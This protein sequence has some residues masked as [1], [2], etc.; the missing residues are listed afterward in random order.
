MLTAPTRGV[1]ANRTL[2]LRSVRAVGFDM[3]YTL[4]HYRVEKWEQ[5]AYEHARSRLLDRSWP[6]AACS[7]QPEL[8]TLGLIVDLQLGNLVKATRFGYVTQAYHGERAVG[9]DELRRSYN[10][11]LVDL[12]DERWVFLN[13][14]FSISEATLFSQCVDLHDQ[15]KL[16]VQLSYAELYD[17]VRRAID[18]VHVE[19]NLKKQI[20]QN[21]APFVEVDSQVVETLV[22]L[23]RA[24]K[25]LLLITN[26][27][28]SY[29]EALM[30]F[31]FDAELPAATTWR[32]L[33]ELVVVS[34]RKPLFFTDKNP[35]FEVL[36]NQGTLRP[37]NGK[38][39]TGGVYFGGHAGLI[40]EHLGL[41]ADDILYIGDHLYSDVHVSKDLLRWR[42]G[43]V[44]RELEK[45]LLALDTFR[46]QQAQLS[47]L[48]TQKKRLEHEYATR[49]LDLQKADAKDQEQKRAALKRQLQSLR[50]KL[51][52]LDQQIAPLA[53]RASSLSNPRWGLLLRAGI[54][55]SYLARQL[56]RYADIY[57]SRVS[58]LLH[59]TPYAY[60]RAPRVSLPHDAAPGDDV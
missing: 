28:W 46:H 9:F 36:T 53:K 16:P 55:K 42:T 29:T 51:E 25:K 60:L 35:F 57:T 32:D 50:G 59:Y 4:I 52:E 39:K 15:G 56:E 30:R 10:D 1:F 13:T 24:G 54:D 37:I 31:A 14:Y 20:A 21:P 27:E 33:F 48:M 19:G 5:H 49:R 17:Q 12:H 26:S 3:D 18:A 6:V 22:D 38:P 2:N 41:L 43:L 47:E 11:T 7:F 8:A 45:E 44:L 34:A 23:K 40:E 58:N